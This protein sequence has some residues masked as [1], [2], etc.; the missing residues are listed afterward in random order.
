M[1]HDFILAYLVPRHL[2]FPSNVLVQTI[3]YL[4]KSDVGSKL[5]DQLSNASMVDY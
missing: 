4:W 2:N 5:S 3:N 1:I